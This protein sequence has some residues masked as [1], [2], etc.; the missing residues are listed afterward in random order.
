MSLEAQASLF[1]EEGMAPPARPTALDPQAVRSRLN[2][3]LDTL[4]AADTMPLSAH[5]VRM[6]QTVVPNM[7]RWLPDAEAQVICATFARE[8]ERLEPQSV[9]N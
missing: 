1:G 7:T 9:Q 5:D 4:Q 2:R 8:L 6:W 3:L